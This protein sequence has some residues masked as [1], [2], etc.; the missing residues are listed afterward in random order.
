MNRSNEYPGIGGLELL[1]IAFMM[2][3]FMFFCL[4]A[5][6]KFG[7]ANAMDKMQDDLIAAHCVEF[8][9]DPKTGKRWI[10]QTHAADCKY[11]G[12]YKYLQLTTPREI[13]EHK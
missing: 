2:I 13:V 9:I 5:G 8:T 10:Q 6:G 7:E 12:L 1:F 11:D 4:W 3:S